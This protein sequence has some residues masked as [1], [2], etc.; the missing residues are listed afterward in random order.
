[1]ERDDKDYPR[2]SHARIIEHALDD[3][4]VLTVVVTGLKSEPRTIARYKVRVTYQVIDTP[5]S[6]GPPGR[7]DY[8]D[9]ELEAHRGNE[10]F[11]VDEKEE[12]QGTHYITDEVVGVMTQVR[13]E[14]VWETDL[15]GK[16]GKPVYK[17]EFRRHT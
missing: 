16:N 1:M 15:F 10:R 12:W 9:E 8:T 4:T 13:L 3:G 14:R 6:S 2:M 5:K 7:D 11:I 17:L